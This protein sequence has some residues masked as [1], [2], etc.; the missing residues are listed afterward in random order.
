M[1]GSQAA[2]FA[3]TSAKGG[4]GK[5]FFAPN[6]AVALMRETKGRV[7]L[8]D[9]DLA[10]A[11][12]A[13]APL[14]N[15]PP[16]RALS[17]LAP[18]VGSLP[19][20]MLKGYL[21][22]HPSGLSYLAACHRPDQA[23][24][25]EPAAVARCLELL[26]QAF[27]ILVLDLDTGYGPFNQACLDQASHLFMLLTPDLYAVNHT[28]QGLEQLQALGFARQM[29]S[30]VLNRQDPKG[31]LGPEAVAARLGRELAGVIPEDAAAVAQSLHQRSLLI[32]DR[33]R[34]PISRALDELAASLWARG[35]ADLSQR[36]A[37]LS[38]PVSATPAA[39]AGPAA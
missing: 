16:R 12:D 13:L 2:V 25:L 27:D 23:A 29:V 7:L 32:L 8:V 11:G 31:E 3:V 1:N 19:A 30:L 39:P 4:V 15:N 9:L 10:W 36:R 24:G 35:V 22:V 26:S 5:S 17:D 18:L 14:G 38:A 28:C 34:H 37:R 20:S 21:D 33:P 6:F